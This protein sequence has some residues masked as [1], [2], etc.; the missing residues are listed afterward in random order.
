MRRE[1]VESLLSIDRA[2]VFFDATLGPIRLKHP[3]GVAVAP[4]GAVWCGGDGGEIYRIE[5][6]GSAIELIAST[7]GFTLGLAFD[8]QGRLYTC[9]LGH[10]AIV[11]LDAQRKLDQFATGGRGLM[12]QTPNYPV[13]DSARGALYVSDS[14]AQGTRGPGVWRFDLETSSGGPWF[15]APLTFAN[16]MAL[17]PDRQWLYVVETFARKVSRIAI[18]QD[19]TAGA[20]ETV[21]EKIER[22]PDGIAFDAVG[23]LY[24]ACYEPSRLFR[25]D[26]DGRL[27]LLVDDPDA[28]TLCHPTNCAFRGTELLTANLGRWHI[29]AIDVGERG[30]PLL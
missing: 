3:E 12:L 10:R 14:H 4:D 29:T 27:E 26:L 24:I 18:N 13:V 2:R 30:S 5:P 15:D 28:H 16:G 11:R 21:V 1:K 17:S 9:D 8:A 22:L 6:D 20:I 23:R 25:V 19:G 7:G